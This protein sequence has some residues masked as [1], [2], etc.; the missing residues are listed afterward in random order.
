[1]L[2][3]APAMI[4]SNLAITFNILNISTHDDGTGNAG[5]DSWIGDT[6]VKAYLAEP[7]FLRGGVDPRSESPRDLP[8]DLPFTKGCN[9]HAESFDVDLLW[10]WL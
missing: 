9:V 1:M 2:R 5:S 6:A 8:L 4:C 3:G 10:L 7:A